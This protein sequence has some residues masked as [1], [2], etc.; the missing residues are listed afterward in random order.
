MKGISESKF[1]DLTKMEQMGYIKEWSCKCNECGNKWHYLDST[2]REI[3]NNV[4][5]NAL[6][7]VSAC[8]GSPVGVYGANKMKDFQS[9]LRK[10]SQCPNCQSSN[11]ELVAKYYR[12]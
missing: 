6:V 7:G 4:K 2:K 10:L 11:F 9:E 12:K 1:N 3:E 8:F 5:T